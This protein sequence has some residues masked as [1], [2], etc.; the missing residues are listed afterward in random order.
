MELKVIFSLLKN[1][2]AVVKLIF[3]VEVIDPLPRVV[4][5]KI[6]MIIEVHS[7]FF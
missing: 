5:V 7:F 2:I 4:I 6:R 1:I 3:S